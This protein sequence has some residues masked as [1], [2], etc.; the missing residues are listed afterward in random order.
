MAYKRAAWLFYFQPISRSVIPATGTNSSQQHIR[1]VVDRSLE[2]QMEMA[3]LHID[4]E[5]LFGPPVVASHI[6]D[7]Y[8]TLSEE[9]KPKQRD[10]QRTCHVIRMMEKV[11]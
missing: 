2:F 4:E 9:E 11:R 5:F 1:Y 3:K 6:P 10:V 8:D 7:D